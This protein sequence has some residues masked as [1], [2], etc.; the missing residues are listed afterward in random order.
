LK[1]VLAAEPVIDREN[2]ATLRV[3]ELG[4]YNGFPTAK[5]ALK[6]AAFAEDPESFQ[7]NF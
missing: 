1:K 4:E 6:C 2:P 3:L 7:L 5:V